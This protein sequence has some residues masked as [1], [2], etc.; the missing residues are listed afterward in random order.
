M[1]RK[2]W[3]AGI[4]ALLMSF[5]L[6][7]VALHWRNDDAVRY[8]EYAIRPTTD[9]QPFVWPDGK[10]NVNTADEE[11]LQTLQGINRSQI[12]ALL[13]DRRTNGKYQYPEDLLCVK[14]IG[15]KTLE[16]L[17]HQLDFSWRAEGI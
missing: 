2:T 17:Y 12:E 7:L 10:V 9:A 6:A 16:K 3:A 1:T 8:A 4:L 5:G 15:E 13:Q 14:G 11:E